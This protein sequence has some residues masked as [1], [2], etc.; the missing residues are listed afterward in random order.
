MNKKENDVEESPNPPIVLSGLH[1]VN[2]QAHSI[3]PTDI[4]RPVSSESTKTAPST[5]SA[6]FS[7]IHMQQR[8]KSLEGH[9]YIC[10]N[11][12]LGHGSFSRVYGG[13][14]C[15]YTP[16]AIKKIP[17][18]EAEK[19]KNKKYLT[20]EIS[21][22]TKL[23]HENI[24][25]LLDVIWEENDLYLVLERCGGGDFKKYLNGQA[26]RERYAQFFLKQL[27]SGLKYLHDNNISHRDL[28]PQ[29]L[30]LSEDYKVLK[31]SD[32]GF[33]KIVGSNALQETICGSPMYMAPEIMDHLPYS[34]KSDLWSVGI[35][36]Y[37]VM[38]GKY[39]VAAKNIFEL[40]KA[41]QSFTRVNFPETPVISKE[42]KH[43]IMSLL[44]KQVELRI[45]WQN[46][47]SHPWF[48][49]IL[50][51]SSKPEVKKQ[52]SGFIQ[53]S[54]NT[55]DIGKDRV[56]EKGNETKDIKK[57]GRDSVK[58][59]GKEGDSML[60]QLS[61][62]GK[63]EKEGML[64]NFEECDEK[65]VTFF[66]LSS[67]E[68]YSPETKPIMATPKHRPTTPFSK[69]MDLPG[70]KKMDLKQSQQKNIPIGKPTNTNVEG[71]KPIT[72]CSVPSSLPSSI[73]LK[74]RQ[75]DRERERERDRQQMEKDLKKQ[76]EQMMMSCDQM[77]MS[78]SPSAG[79]NA[80]LHI[81]STSPFVKSLGPSITFVEDYSSTDVFPA[82]PRFKHYSAP[83]PINKERSN[84]VDED[85]NAIS[86]MGIK[87][88]KIR[89]EDEKE[90]E[91]KLSKTVKE[92]AFGAYHLLK[93]S[94]NSFNGLN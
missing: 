55:N 71:R 84:D 46:F 68:H 38:F 32:F 77:M 49:L 39:P 35:I 58:E 14:A 69:K 57:D 5:P 15:S 86:L 89:E 31:I 18:V 24:V 17:M 34:D 44:T 64:F 13:Y 54:I 66:G 88:R 51:K 27:A 26:M 29:N 48:S 63:S 25:N 62:L 10:T 43:L 79:D 94:F 47:F 7:G 91:K 72:S 82:D 74:G 87:G 30:L 90:D 8:I 37:E 45:S 60:G 59:K 6:A 16:V 41:L 22:M 81:N 20:S 70:D 61:E 67:V 52:G 80:S 85:R 93:D 1:D 3:I 12:L 9:E 23:K 4:V 50:S 28:K 78:C 11:K 33:A 40:M 75:T 36:T 92:Y 2:S 53:T 83:P 42:A 21:I 65:P 73:P 19:E 56:K 76:S